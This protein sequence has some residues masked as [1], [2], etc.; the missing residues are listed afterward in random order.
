M[1]SSTNRRILNVISVSL[2]IVA[3]VIGLTMKYTIEEPI[4]E[5][6]IETPEVELVS[7]SDS[8]QYEIEEIGEPN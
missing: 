5:A 3:M 4:L 1:L 2:A 8:I 7:F 6:Q